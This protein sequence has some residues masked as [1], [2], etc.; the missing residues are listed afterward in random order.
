MTPDPAVPGGQLHVTTTRFSSSPSHQLPIKDDFDRSEFIPCSLPFP[1]F[2]CR[3]QIRHSDR[4]MSGRKYRCLKLIAQTPKE[5][6][7]LVQQISPTGFP[8]KVRYLSGAHLSPPRRW[9]IRGPRGLRKP[10]NKVPN[11]DRHLHP[12]SHSFRGPP[13][14]F[15]T[16]QLSNVPRQLRGS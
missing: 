5:D 3:S 13:S 12:E 4:R 7:K 8:G 2:R 16:R 11:S 10:L 9:C 6:R 14:S 15:P 1:R